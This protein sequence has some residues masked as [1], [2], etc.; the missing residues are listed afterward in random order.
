[1]RF[2]ILE[3]GSREVLKAAI[4]GAA[5]GLALLMWAYNAAAWLQ[6]RDRHLAVNVLVYSALV[7]FEREHLKHHLASAGTSAAST[8]LLAAAA[9]ASAA[10]EPEAQPKAA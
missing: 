10:D 6:R 2:S 5:L 4:H 3:S 7:A 9:L 1:M 8:A